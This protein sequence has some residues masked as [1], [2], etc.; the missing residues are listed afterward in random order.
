MITNLKEFAKEL[1]LS[2]LKM[3]FDSGKNGSHVGPGLSSIEIMATLYG[4]VMHLSLI[5]I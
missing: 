3:A 4:D 1:R 5:H 2:S